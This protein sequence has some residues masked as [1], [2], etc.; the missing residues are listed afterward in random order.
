MLVSSILLFTVV[1]DL[2][3][4]RRSL[5]KLTQS[6]LKHLQYAI[7]RIMHMYNNMAKQQKR[8]KK[9]KRASAKNASLST[10][11]D[12]FGTFFF[13]C[14]L[15]M[16]HGF[17]WERFCEKWYVRLLRLARTMTFLA[18]QWL[19]L[20]TIQGRRRGRVSKI[21]FLKYCATRGRR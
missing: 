20:N 21:S 2:L 5:N 10:S 15:I 6:K 13:C 1:L 4:T 18:K 16:V 14:C 7:D 8:D 3:P 12:C 17:W 19:T 9:G 11:L